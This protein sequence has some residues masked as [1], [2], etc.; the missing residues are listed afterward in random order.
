MQGDGFEGTSGGRDAF[1]ALACSE[2]VVGE[3]LRGG[4]IGEG[5]FDCG[6]EA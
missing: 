3:R 1:V 2:E 4:E 5:H 6:I